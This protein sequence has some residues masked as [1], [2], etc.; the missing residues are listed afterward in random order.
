MI[1]GEE[2]NQKSSLAA[3]PSWE[4]K[5]K[6]GA[7]GR[8]CLGDT[9]GRSGA[10]RTKRTDRGGREKAKSVAR[11]DQAPELTHSGFKKLGRCKRDK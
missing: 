4:Q 7:L 1:L 11:V 9:D 10:H 6:P 8:P 5:L 2:T 3:L